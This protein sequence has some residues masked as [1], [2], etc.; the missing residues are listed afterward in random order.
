MVNSRED[1]IAYDFIE[2]PSFWAFYIALIAGFRMF[3]LA[4]P[5]NLGWTTVAFC[6]FFITF[7]FFHWAK[8]TP[9]MNMNDQGKH[10][11]ET[12]W[13]LMDSGRQFTPARKLLTATPAV[14]FLLAS[15][16]TKWDTGYLLLNGILAGI[17][18]VAKDPRM[19]R[20]RIFGIN[21]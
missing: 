11:K 19:V 17:L 12:F 10:E 18:L 16:E 7:Y 15:M 13:E 9:V 1:E 8:G 21:K 6:H 3:L 4:L 5:G 2:Q 20:V 14:L